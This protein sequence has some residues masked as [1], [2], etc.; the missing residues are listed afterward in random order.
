MEYTPKKRMLNA[1]RGE[2]S[3][4]YPVAPEFW[5]YYPAKLLGV[6]MVEFERE[7]PMWEALQKTFVHYGT[8]GWGVAGA[9]QTIP[10]Q[11]VE[12]SFEK[13]GEG[14][15]V[16][17]TQMKYRDKVFSTA[18][19]Y[20]KFEP[21]WVTEHAVKDEEDL[22]AF[23]EMNFHPDAEYDFAGANEAHEKVGGDYLLELALPGPFF[24]VVGS[25]MGFQD[26]VFYFLNEEPDQL[27]KLR[28]MYVESTVKQVRAAVEKTSFE[29]FFIGCEYSCNSLIGP[30]MWREWDKP[31]LKAA[32]DELHRHGKHLHI[33]F[34]GNC[35]E[36][37]EDFA[38]IGIDC[39]CPFER[40]PG[41]DLEGLE[42][43]RKVRK[44]LDS[45]VTMNGNVHTIE[46]LIRGTEEDVRREVREIKEA[47]KGEPRLVIGSGDQIGY[48]T[49]EENIYAM[50]DE[51]KAAN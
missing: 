37:V 25:A 17:K 19:A 51:A 48:E 15:Y 28:D 5:S 41:G 3:D 40:P 32:V 4:R 50:V 38:E 33:H 13:T 36:T 7:V 8:E 49:P 39:V 2:F 30:D 6:D 45:K 21:S 10:D 26:A 46:T 1:Y 44:L 47:F 29:S 43:L 35:M 20:D 24:D 14:Q 27:R 18:R 11:T 31:G 16:S 23:F 9:G 42:G 22:A 34:H 12:S